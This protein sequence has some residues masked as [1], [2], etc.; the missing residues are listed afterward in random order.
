MAAHSI[1]R[2][3][4]RRGPSDSLF[5]GIALAAFALMVTTTGCATKGYVNKR[6][7]ESQASTDARITTLDGELQSTNSLAAQALDKA[8]L[9]EKLAS[10]AIDYTVVSTHEMRFAFDDYRLDSESMS[11]LD[12]LAGKLAARPRGVLEIRGFAD[13]TGEDRYNY[14]LGRE[15]AESVERYLV[16]RHG[17]APARVAILSMGEEEPAADNDSASGRAQNRR[18]AARLLEITPKSGDPPVA[19]TE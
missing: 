15:R 11:L 1:A 14:R 5:A 2:F 12:D 13:A 19:M 17:V 4:V 9:A 8:T 10:G 6:V 16:T 18:V 3:G 7:A